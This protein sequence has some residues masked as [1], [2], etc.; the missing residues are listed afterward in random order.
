MKPD[1]KASVDYYVKPIF[2]DAKQLYGREHEVQVLQ[3]CFHRLMDDGDPSIDAKQQL[4]AN[5]NIE[6][7]DRDKNISTESPDHS[8]SSVDTSD[9]DTL[10]RGDCP[11]KR[12]SKPAPHIRHSVRQCS[13]ISIQYESTLLCHAPHIR[14]CV[15]LYGA[16]GMGKRS[17]ARHALEPLVKEN[18]GWYLAGEFE[19]DYFGGG[20][21]SRR[22]CADGGNKRG[23]RFA[24]EKEDEDGISACS[25][26]PLSGI[27]SVCRQICAKLL[28]LRD[29]ES[30]GDTSASDTMLKRSEVASDMSHLF[31]DTVKKCIHALSLEERRLLIKILGLLNPIFGMENNNDSDYYEPKIDNIAHHKK[32]LHYAFQKFISVISKI[33]GP[34]VISFNNFQFADDASLD[35]LESL[36][37]DREIDKLMVVGCV[38]LTDH[39]EKTNESIP[40][41]D[42]MSR[43][44]NT[45][46]EMWR[47]EVSKLFG[48]NVTDVELKN[49]SLDSTKQILMD[50]LSIQDDHNNTS[51]TLTDMISRKDNI[52]S[53]VELCYEYSH[54]NTY[55]TKRFLEI[56]HKKKLL[57]IDQRSGK[58]AWD[59][60]DV[61]SVVT[62]SNVVDVILS[63]SAN[64]LPR[65]AKSLLLLAI[66]MGRTCIDE[67][68][69][70][71]V[72]S[73]FERKPRSNVD[74]QSQF[75]LYINESLYRKVL[76]KVEHP[77][78]GSHRAYHFSHESM[79][80]ALSGHVDSH[81]IGSLRYEIGSTLEHGISEETDLLV[82]AKL[83]NSG[84]NSLLGSLDSKKRVKWAKINLMAAKKAVLMSAFD[85]A[86]QYAEAGIEYLPSS[87]RWTDHCKLMLELSSILGEVAGALGEL[88]L[89]HC[90]CI[91]LALILWRIIVQAT[92][93]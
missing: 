47:D 82:V 16:Q 26:I 32:K 49:V 66:C 41:A 58:W 54:G 15:F 6:S 89:L 53:L 30:D 62:S 83:I 60:Y 92:V 67:D 55:Y 78:A 72:W 19:K 46:I 61:T 57:H 69:L 64:K 25:G 70:F 42:K 68:L 48:L 90:N 5:D 44:L 39:G 88:I 35:L 22:R 45:K 40:L 76:V 12:Q 52:A 59:L 87:T 79:I 10:G 93:G 1:P 20:G 17:L 74:V 29:S 56:L 24:D 91:T 34:L 71:Q 4:D 9:R 21:R 11:T 43:K 2:D 50:V 84:G 51:Q 63:E 3:S 8:G 38:Q 73:K 28:E 37:F 18:G 7:K 23:V 65:Q 85:S 81:S 27:I 77:L 75:R 33:H 36:L 86:T 31:D 80:S 14:E 13:D